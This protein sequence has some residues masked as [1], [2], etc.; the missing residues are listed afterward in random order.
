MLLL[1]SILLIGILLGIGLG[2]DPRNLA[3]V[4]V[5]GWWLIPLALVLQLLPIPQGDSGFERALPVAVVLLSYIGL[6]VVALVNWRLRGFL[7]ILL[8]LTLNFTVIGINQGMPVSE[9]ALRQTGNPELMEGL[10]QQRGGKHHLANER[11]VL[12]PFADVIAFRQPFGVV[13]SAGDLAIDTGGAIFLAAAIL[14]RPERPPLA[15]RPHPQRAQQA[16][17][18]GTPR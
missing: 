15:P 9:E 8:G 11:D 7:L 17:M 14:G 10:P 4:N 2:G 16:E 5:R 6:I 12:L 1:L 18:W 3:E 13:V